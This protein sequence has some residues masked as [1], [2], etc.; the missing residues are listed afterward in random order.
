[1]GPAVARNEVVS[2]LDA[3]DITPAEQA[4]IDDEP[5]PGVWANVPVCSDPGD[6]RAFDQEQTDILIAA[7]IWF[8]S[9]FGTAQDNR[10]LRAL[11]G[12]PRGVAL[13]D[14]GTQ[15]RVAT[16][17]RGGIHSDPLVRL[18][19]FRAWGDRDRAWF[20]SANVK[21][22]ALEE[23]AAVYGFD[24]LRMLDQRGDSTR[25]E[26]LFEARYGSRMGA[27]W[28]RCDVAVSDLVKHAQARLDEIRRRLNP[29]VDVNPATHTY[30]PLAVLL[31]P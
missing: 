18:L 19:A 30:R 22:R 1:M 27:I 13:D 24:E 29:R 16:R 25:P 21:A 8:T 4:A 10:E 28:M 2:I 9:G 11:V 7:E 20:E 3:S 12:E 5:R 26:V 31:A 23:I 6:G 15:R 17:Q 14:A